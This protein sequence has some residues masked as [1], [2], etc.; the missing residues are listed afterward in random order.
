M[1]GSK[2]D[3]YRCSFCGKSSHQVRKLIAGRTR[4]TFIC[5]ECVGLCTEI[6]HEELMDEDFSQDI[7]L[8]L[9]PKL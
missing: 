9:M 3:Q 4:N 1:A 6:I 8:H 5:D 7:H 2:E